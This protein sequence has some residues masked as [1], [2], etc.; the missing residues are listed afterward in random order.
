MKYRNFGP[1]GRSLS[2]SGM[3]AMPHSLDA[4]RPDEEEAIALIHDAIDCGITLVEN[5][6]PFCHRRADPFKIH[7]IPPT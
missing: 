3:G 6:H 2:A 7:A 1:T 4:N 5:A